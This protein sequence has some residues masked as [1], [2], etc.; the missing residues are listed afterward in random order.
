MY[1]YSYIKAIWFRVRGIQKGGCHL[2]LVYYRQ[3]G[4]LMVYMICDLSLSV[5]IATCG[6][7][8]TRSGPMGMAFLWRGWSLPTGMG[9]DPP[10]WGPR[11]MWSSDLFAMS[12]DLCR[13]RKRSWCMQDCGELLASYM[14]NTVLWLRLHLDKWLDRPD[15]I[16][17]LVTSSPTIAF[18][19][20]SFHFSPLQFSYMNICIL[21]WRWLC[22]WHGFKSTL[23]FV[24]IGS[25]SPWVLPDRTQ[26]TFRQY[27]GRHRPYQPHLCN[28][29]LWSYI[30]S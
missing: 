25:M 3:W 20:V 23:S 29:H 4:K 1:K 27:P 28:Q 2:A 12:R 26:G 18:R 14:S 8:P 30:I 22:C 16:N 15:P 9:E 19:N 11:V 6:S 24:L 5:C 17:R 21:R 10:Y 7:L 13:W